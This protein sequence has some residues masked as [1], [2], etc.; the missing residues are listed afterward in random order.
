MPKKTER[1]TLWSRP[2]LYL[3][4]K[5]FWFSSWGQQVRFGGFLKLCRTFG[6]ELF[7]SLQVYQKIFIKKT[8]AKRHDYSRLSSLEKR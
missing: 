2:V 5:H 7:W 3:R 4:G 1:G 6:V 8:M